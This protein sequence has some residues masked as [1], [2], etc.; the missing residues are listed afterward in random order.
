[1]RLLDPRRRAGPTRA[2]AS[3][4]DRFRAVG[5]AATTR[6][7]GAASDLRPGRPL[8]PRPCA[9]RAVRPRIDRGAR[10]NQIGS[11]TDGDPDD[12]PAPLPT[13]GTDR[14]MGP[15]TQAGRG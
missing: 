6:T 12:E 13:G 3:G 7:R 15:T 8:L 11:A 1:M 4:A 14:V 10:S 2:S 5:P 9:G